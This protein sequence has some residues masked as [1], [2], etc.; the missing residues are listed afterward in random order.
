M[1]NRYLFTQTNISGEPNSAGV[2]VLYDNAE[3]IYYGRAKG[4]EV[5]IR[6]RLSDHRS[7]REG[8]CT[9]SATH[10]SREIT[11]SPVSREKE[12]LQQFLLLNR[13]LPRCNDKMP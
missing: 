13:R 1:T 5:T 8:K 6:S 11:S 3:V 7:G 2:Y 12:L 10:Y 9:Q 4:G